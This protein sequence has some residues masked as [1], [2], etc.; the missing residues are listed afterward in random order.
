MGESSPLSDIRLAAA[1]HS[2]AAARMT[3]RARR[4][5]RGVL[6]RYFR[7]TEDLEDGVQDVVVRVMCHLHQ[8]RASERFDSWVASI[9]RRV[10]LARQRDRRTL[11]LPLGLPE[12]ERAGNPAPDC[13]PIAIALDLARER[14][15]APRR[16]LLD[17]RYRRD[18]SY[19]EIAERLGVTVPVVRRR[20]QGARDQLRKEVLR[21]MAGEHGEGIHLTHADLDC[22]YG[23]AT[24][25]DPECDTRMGA[26][27][28]WE[29]LVMGGSTHR[30]AA[31]RLSSKEPLP[32]LIL[33]PEP[34]LE[35]RDHRDAREAVLGWTDEAAIL[36]LD[37][38]TRLTARRLQREPLTEEAAQAVFGELP[39]STNASYA[40]MLELAETIAGVP[41]HRDEQD[42]HAIALLAVLPGGGIAL[43][44]FGRGKVTYAMSGML[45]SSDPGEP[46]LEMLLN[47]GYLRDCLLA[48]PQ[49]SER[50][51]VDFG[52]AHTALRFVNPEFPDFSVAMMPIHRDTL[53]PE[54]R[55]TW[56]ELLTRQADTVSAGRA[57]DA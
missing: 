46:G 4:L 41:W 51:R 18:L 32:T 7:C 17:L 34:F 31:G 21:Y 38:G 45:G 30:A 8:L 56:A 24:L 6:G 14:L 19:A 52:G 9:A 49:G 3:A 16:Q 50:V 1:G 48:L 57:S 25:V 27:H 40:E 47:R 5:A 35:L 36:A 55:Q 22:L 12:A 42:A 43:Q 23:A 28:V 11:P 39:H 2:G 10:A 44:A 20:L 54:E 29:G 37:D 33:D 13:R 53:T 26:L 15:S